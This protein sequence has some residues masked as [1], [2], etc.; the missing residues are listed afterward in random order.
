[1]VLVLRLKKNMAFF[2]VIGSILYK[3]YFKEIEIFILKKYVNEQS[4]LTCLEYVKINNV[5]LKFCICF[6][7]AFVIYSEHIKF[8]MY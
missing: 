3:S 8:Y 5:D 7:R 1:L 2:L 4:V 6:G